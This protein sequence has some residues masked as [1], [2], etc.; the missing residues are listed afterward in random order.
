MKICCLGDSLTEGDYGV[1]GKSGIANIQPENYPYYLGIMSGADVLN[2]GRCGYR[3]TNYLEY[4]QSG[5]VDV[6]D[7]DLIIIMLGTNGGQHPEQ[8]TPDNKAYRELVALCRQDA[9]SA[10]IVLCTPP[11]VTED[12]AMSN[13][14][15][16]PQV[17]LAVDFV[18][19]FAQRENLKLIDVAACE[20]FN[21]NTEHIY[22]SND[23]LH[24]NQLGYEALATYIYQS[25][26]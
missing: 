14:G 25:I 3:A 23:G 24:F 4:Y 6:K 2:F 17:A 12:P 8:D 15:H 10:Q 5:N 9:P 13:C 21:A 20:K 26:R 22:Q 1:P 18:R 7:A 11:H 19:S 16:A